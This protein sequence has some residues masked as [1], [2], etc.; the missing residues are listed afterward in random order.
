MSYLKS[1]LMDNNEGLYI[2]VTDLMNR[3]NNIRLLPKASPSPSPEPEVT[4]YKLHF[5]SPIHIGDSAVFKAWKVT[6]PVR[7][8]ETES[9]IPW[10]NDQQILNE[11]LSDYENAESTGSGHIVYGGAFS[12]IQI[13][14]GC[15]YSAKDPG[16]TYFSNELYFAIGDPNE[17]FE[18]TGQITTFNLETSYNTETWFKP[19]D[20][21]SGWSILG[22]KH[23]P[24]VPL[25]Y[26]GVSGTVDL[27]LVYRYKCPA[28]MISSG[29]SGFITD[30]VSGVLEYPEITYV[31]QMVDTTTMRFIE[32]SVSKYLKQ[33]Y[34]VGNYIDYLGNDSYTV[35]KAVKDFTIYTLELPDTTETTLEFS[36]ESFY[37][38]LSDS[39]AYT[40]KSYCNLETSINYTNF[41]LDVKLYDNTP[42]GPKNIYFV[43]ALYGY[44]IPV[45]YPNSSDP[46][47]ILS[48]KEIFIKDI[49]ASL[50]L[51]T[52][53]VYGAVNVEPKTLTAEGYYIRS[54]INGTTN[55]TTYD[56][57]N[58]RWWGVA[59]L[60]PFITSYTADNYTESEPELGNGG[61]YKTRT[62][63]Y[64]YVYDNKSVQEYVGACY[65]INNSFL[66]KE[67]DLLT[68]QRDTLSQINTTD[69]EGINWGTTLQ[70][71]GIADSDYKYGSASYNK[72]FKD[73]IEKQS[74]TCAY[75]TL[76]TT[77]NVLDYKDSLTIV[78]TK[79][80]SV[81]NQDGTRNNHMIAFFVKDSLGVMRLIADYSK[82]GNEAWV[83]PC[84][85]H[86]YIHVGDGTG[87]TYDDIGYLYFN[88]A[89]IVDFVGGL[90]S[91]GVKALCNDID[92]R[93]LSTFIG[94]GSLV[95]DSSKDVATTLGGVLIVSNLSY[96]MKKYP[97]NEKIY[98]AKNNTTQGFYNCINALDSTK[99]VV[100]P[101]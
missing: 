40:E 17:S 74:D 1:V 94:N 8:I 15:C 95:R 41:G 39:W 2:D 27:E 52:T 44:T 10:R 81:F 89:S 50:D 36:D 13:A 38:V 56:G 55:G 75:T 31:N 65:S 98:Y 28:A 59:T 99:I 37:Y 76:V 18:K 33:I 66:C 29:I 100:G 78:S 70:R 26:S 51:Q 62:Y 6:Y 22:N 73:L 84:Q 24:G 34:S 69:I 77:N 14:K 60:T 71:E 58:C 42:K 68:L 12:N 46:V 96:T 85:S 21:S 90:T 30:M 45:Y 87:K 32:G 48:R 79:F 83:T 61:L 63:D 49:A 5:W 20:G 82:A 16:W 64:E 57:L 35:R 93:R 97:D 7:I 23:N 92:Y 43:N 91:G 86:A 9:E 80:S 67:S 19:S 4:D 11:S 72:A 88:P 25:G 101:N 3:L 54:Q 47:Y 53:G